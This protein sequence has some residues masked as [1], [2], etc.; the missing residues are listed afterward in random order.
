MLTIIQG[1]VVSLDFVVL[2]LLATRNMAYWLPVA[3]LSVHP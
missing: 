2:N 3:W 1:T